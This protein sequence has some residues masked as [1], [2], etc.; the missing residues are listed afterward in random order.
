MH[1]HPLSQRAA[2]ASC[3]LLQF[4]QI[5]VHPRGTVSAGRLSAPEKIGGSQAPQRRQ[6]VAE[7]P[8]ARSSMCRE[9]HTRWQRGW[10]A[11]RTQRRWRENGRQA[12]R[13][14]GLR[15]RFASYWLG[16]L[17]Q[18]APPLH[19]TARAVINCVPQIM[20]RASYNRF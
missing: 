6:A 17:G 20:L 1:R 4:F 14:P 10:R 5:S 13:S 7:P 18:K 2:A 3:Q 15:P 11:Q 12:V 9:P 8:M 16:G 19:P